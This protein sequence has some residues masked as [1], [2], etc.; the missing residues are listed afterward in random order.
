[1]IS[2]FITGVMVLFSL[3]PLTSLAQSKCT[4]PCAITGA[5]NDYWPGAANAAAGTSAIT[6]GTKRAAGTGVAGIALAAGD[7]VMVIQMQ[8]A[9]INTANTTTYGANNGTGSGYLLANQTGFYE[10]ATVGT[11]TGAVITLTKP[12]VN[13]YNNTVVTGAQTKPTFQI[14]RVPNCVTMD[15]SG[16]IIGAPWNGSTGGIVALRGY[17]VNMGSAT[18][19]ANGIGFRGGA[20]DAHNGPGAAVNYNGT[21]TADQYKGEGIAGTP[22]FLYDTATATEIA[23]GLTFPGGYRGVGAPANA[24]GAGAGDAGGGGGGNGGA[25]GRGG[26]WSLANAGG[27]G[28]AL[29]GQASRLRVTMGGG[30][31]GGSA[32]T[33]ATTGLETT[34]PYGTGVNSFNRGGA[35]GG[36]VILGATVRTGALTINASGSVAT[37]TTYT[38]TTQGSR[39]GGG[40]GAGGSVVLYGTGGT[41]VAN[42]LGGNGYLDIAANHIAHGGGGGGGLVYSNGA[43][44]GVTSAVT[45]GLAGCSQAGALT[46]TLSISCVATDTNS[47]TNGATGTVALFASAPEPGGP[48]CS[49]NLSVSKTDGA[50]SIPAG[51]TT[52]YTINVVNSGPSPANNSLLKDPVAPGLNCTSVL[53]SASVPAGNCPLAANT[54]IPLLQSTGIVLGTL[55]AAS[56]LTFQVTCGVTATGQ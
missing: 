17:T 50:V 11:V 21:S 51:T 7:L 27:L 2:W 18:I 6:L 1:M 10:Y 19:N 55:P 54:T 9:T 16:T 26:S 53:C 52:T 43:L 20:T 25:G 23:T 56:T 32:N 28:G 41:I 34:I 30:G 40:G 3:L 39:V 45:A 47:S 46:D 8:D 4:D 42:A 33:G 13:T 38:S 22:D 49:A 48:T 44:T 36:I 29:F 24:G 5:P 15:L 31:A 35:G 12:L 14:I 37:G